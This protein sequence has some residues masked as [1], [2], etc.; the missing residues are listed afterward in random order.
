MLRRFDNL[1]DELMKFD[2]GRGMVLGAAM[3]AAALLGIHQASAAEPVSRLPLPDN[4]PFPISA[5]VSVS[6]GTDLYYLSGA[7]APPINKDAPKG[8]TAAYGDME[9]Q[10]T[11]SLTAIKGTL[12]RLGLG[13]G[14]VIKMT[15]FL[16][17]DP[18]TNKLDFEGFMTGYKKFFGT[19]EQPNK[20]A[21]SAVQIA[22][23]VAP[24]ALVEIEVVAAKP[25][26]AAAKSGNTAK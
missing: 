19:P 12:E 20:P 18:T 21:R 6:A 15:A 9:T 2:S 11:N 1:R 22:A 13:M 16:V 4:N 25:H 3:F 17:A 24:G 14:D 26:K 23:L 7:V 5:A 10:A 8:S